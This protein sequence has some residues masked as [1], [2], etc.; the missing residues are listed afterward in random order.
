MVSKADRLLKAEQRE[1]DRDVRVRRVGPAVR[2]EGRRR[3]RD[4][5]RDARGAAEP[6]P[7]PW[8]LL[9]RGDGVLLLR[10]PV[11]RPRCLPLAERGRIRRDGPGDPRL[12]HVRV[13]S[14][15]SGRHDRQ[16]RV[17]SHLGGRS[18]GPENV[19]RFRDR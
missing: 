11:L 17:S 7:V 19:H 16:R 12:Q 2:G 18:R 1:P 8:V 10:E 5:Q 9:R 15:R 3:G 14:E 6:V 4:H 13:L